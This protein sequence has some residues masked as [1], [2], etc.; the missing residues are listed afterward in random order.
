ME[1]FVDPHIGHILIDPPYFILFGGP[2]IH[3]LFLSRTPPNIFLFLV[4]PP[5]PSGSQME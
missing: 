1:K 5:P 3:V 4:S 2:S